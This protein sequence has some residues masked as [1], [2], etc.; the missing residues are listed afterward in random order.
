MKNPN[1]WL[2]TTLFAALVTAC[3]NLPSPAK[4]DTSEPDNLVGAWRS[5]IRFAGGALAEIKDLEFMYVFN[6]GGTMT[7]SSNYDAAPPVP[8]AYGVW[9]KS[10]PHQFEARYAFYATRAPGTFEEIAKGGGWSPSGHGV[11][12]ERI[13]LS[14]DGKSYRSTITYAAFDRTGKPV[15][16]GGEGV[17][18]ATR[19]GF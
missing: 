16:G 17:G 3:G 9:R 5:Q 1:R 15:D 18:V 11:L 8:P 7:E 2:L 10:G 4:G 14:G 12:T 19:M 13:T 6:A